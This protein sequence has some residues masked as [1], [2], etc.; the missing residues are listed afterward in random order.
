MASTL[1]NAGSAGATHLKDRVSDVA[2][3]V[4]S[5]VPDI[6]VPDTDRAYAAVAD[7]G[8][9]VGDRRNAAAASGR[10]YSAALQ[11]RLSEGLEKQPLLLGAIGL[12]AA[13]WP[14]RVA[15][16]WIKNWRNWCANS[17]SFAGAKRRKS[18]GELM[19]SSK[20]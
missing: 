6:S 5:L 19:L 11:S 4:A 2:G 10:E 20:G 12:P 17:G 1:S 18:A 14:P 15:T 13:K 9:A 16:L 3:S 8:A 7:A